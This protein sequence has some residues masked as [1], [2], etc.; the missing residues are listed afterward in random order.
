MAATF[1][2]CLPRRLAGILYIRI[3]GSVNLTRGQLVD[4][5]HPAFEDILLL[6]AAGDRGTWLQ[7][8][9]EPRRNVKYG[10]W[11]VDCGHQAY[12]DER[13]G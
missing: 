12:G 9:A 3:K 13:R 1:T 5:T 11:T 6:H 8:R 7:R 4:Q 2:H 10:S